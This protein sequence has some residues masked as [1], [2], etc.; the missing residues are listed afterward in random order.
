MQV[1]WY[2]KCYVALPHGAVGWSAVCDHGISWS[3]LLTFGGYLPV[4]T[5]IEYFT[6]WFRKSRCILYNIYMYTQTKKQ[7]PIFMVLCLSI[8][9]RC[10]NKNKTIMFIKRRTHKNW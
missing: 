10:R 6:Q 1:Y 8:Q 3:Y 7:R 9:L 4:Q 5:V 2:Y